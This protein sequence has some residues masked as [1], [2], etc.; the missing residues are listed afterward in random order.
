MLNNN[1]LKVLLIGGFSSI[2]VFNPSFG[3]TES[4]DLFGQINSVDLVLNDIWIEPENPKEGEV[5]S[6]HGSVYN[7]GIVP[8]GDVSDAVTIAYIVNGEI[9]EI[10]LLEN[11]IPGLKNGMEISSGPV[12]DAYPGSNIITVIINYHDTLS[13]LRDNPANNIVQKRIDI[14]DPRPSLIDSEIYQQYNEET[15]E[16]QIT[17][18]GELTDFFQEKVVNREIIIDVGTIFQEKVITNINGTFSLTTSIPFADNTV[19]VKTDLKDISLLTK[20][21][22]SIYPIKLNEEE[23][24]LALEIIPNSSTHNFEN[25]AFTIVLFQD[26]YDNMFKKISIN[27]NDEKTR[28]LDDIFLTVVPA[29]HEYIAEIYYEGRLLSA[30][31][32]FFANNAVIKKDVFIPEYG[33]VKFRAL[34]DFNEPRTKIIIDNW[35][36]SDVTGEDGMTDW[37]EM[38]PTVTSNEPYVAKAT[39]LDGTIVWSEPFL[40]DSDEKKVISII[41]GAHK[42]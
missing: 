25:S 22:Q 42:P 30:F 13:H 2:L 4:V 11:I 8:S 3:L 10:N 17:I 7:A 6:I 33:Q 16:Q 38:V 29:N 31:Q 23:S 40:L 32:S 34:D 15:K 28:I 5:V 26:S 39:F 19:E 18:R 37:I 20:T 35:I 14:G 36:Y 24:I 41:K 27:N 1:I 9:V 12:F 21:S